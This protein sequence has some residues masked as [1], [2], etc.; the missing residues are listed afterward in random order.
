[1]PIDSPTR[2]LRGVGEDDGQNRG[3]GTGISS[4]AA[5]DDVGGSET[6]FERLEGLAR[7]CQSFPSEEGFETETDQPQETILIR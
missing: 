5:I 1:M 3:G 2:G 4:K 7:G 6:G